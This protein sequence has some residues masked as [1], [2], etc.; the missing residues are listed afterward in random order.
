[1]NPLI[2]ILY[3]NY[4]SPLTATTKESKRRNRQGNKITLS[5]YLISSS[6]LKIFLSLKENL[7]SGIK[8]IPISALTWMHSKLAV[9]EGYRWNNEPKLKLWIFSKEQKL[10]NPKIMIINILLSIVCNI[11]N[12]I[13]S[14]YDH[15]LA[16]AR[17]IKKYKNRRLK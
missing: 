11:R 10:T 8:I 12:I 9:K 13:T 2:L 5:Y 6:R 17:Y 3:L 1:M 16:Y 15:S 4:W 14:T 7:K